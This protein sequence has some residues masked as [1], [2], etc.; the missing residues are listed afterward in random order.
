MTYRHRFGLSDLGFELTTDWED[1]YCFWRSYTRSFQTDA[2]PKVRYIA[3]RGPQPALYW[4]GDE[5]RPVRREVDLY[6]LLEDLFLRDLLL[7]MQRRYP[8]Y[9]AAVTARDGGATIFLGEP[10]AGKSSLCVERVRQGERY[11]SDEMAAVDGNDVI[12]LPRPISFNTLE[13]PGH[14]LP[15][16]DSR[17]ESLSYRFLDRQGQWETAELF[18]PEPTRCAAAGERWPIEGV[19]LLESV[20]DGPPRLI[21]QAGPARRAHLEIHRFDRPKWGA[22]IAT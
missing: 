2:P 11:L 10:N 16:G 15:R 8:V 3:K 4:A 19:T 6:P 14:L 5:P 22:K 13:N 18:I 7:L 9:H 1:L 20:E 17:F 21:P 12:A